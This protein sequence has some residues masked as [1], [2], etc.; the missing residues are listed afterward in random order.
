M[1]NFLNLHYFVLVAEKKN[2]TRVAEDEHISQQSL[3]KHIKKIEDELGIELIDRSGGCSLTYAGE[4]FY[5]Y[6]VRLLSLKYEMQ[7][8]MLDM[9]ENTHGN[10]RLG[11]TYTRGRTFLPEILPEYCRQNPFVKVTVAENN[12]HTLEEYLLHGHIDLY[13][14]IDIRKHPDIETVD[15]YSDN[16]YLIVPKGI[17]AEVIGENVPNILPRSMRL[18]EF[19]KYNFV[20]LTRGNPI[21]K[22]VDNYMRK[23]HL[24]LSFSLET[25]NSETMFALACKNMGIAIYN[26]FFLKMHTEL[27]SSNNCPICV[28][29]LEGADY[30]S[31]M[32]IG[33]IK[34]RYMPQ[35][36]ARFIQTA[37]KLFPL[38]PETK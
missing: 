33:Y 14:G 36:T 9:K 5:S 28:I 6:A 21:R 18:E 17:A 1:I 3:S 29:P 24:S 37:R 7:A 31:M 19:A 38:A 20:M 32:S 34:N 4:R 11:V 22:T 8:E 12:P 30:N 2:I 26:D 25:E 10:L 23:H 27:I 15:L 16:L 13:I 35:A